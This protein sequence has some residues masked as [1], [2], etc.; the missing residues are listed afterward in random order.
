[1]NSTVRHLIDGKP[2]SRRLD[3]A[4]NM[5]IDYIESAL[6]LHTALYPKCHKCKKNNCDECEEE[7]DN[8]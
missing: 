7:N 6:E 3:R 1:M 8:K 5:V 2:D 4:F